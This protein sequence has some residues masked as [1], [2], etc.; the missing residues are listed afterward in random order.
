MLHIDKMEVGN[1]PPPL[2]RTTMN[3]DQQQSLMLIA[4]LQKMEI[5]WNSRDKAFHNT[6]RK[7]EAWK[8]LAEAMNAEVGEVKRKVDSLRGS[9]RREKSRLKRAMAS[10]GGN[11]FLKILYCWLQAFG[12]FINRV[13]KHAFIHNKSVKHE[14][15]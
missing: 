15:I 3:W 8:Q 1:A 10:G 7:E 12:S 5:L 4:E 2:V 6:Q 14:F 13:R 11:M 9:Y